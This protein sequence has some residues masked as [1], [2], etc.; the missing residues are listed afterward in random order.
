LALIDGVTP[1]LVEALFRLGWR[2]AAD[3]SHSKPDELV[4]VPGIDA[5]LAPR[6][7]TSA[8]AVEAERR[9]QAEEAT[10]AA[11][12]V[13]PGPGEGADAVSPSSTPEGP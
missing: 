11:A 6:L 1:E 13:A 5:D 3:V 4:E 9:R 7:I 2:S 12:A 10:L 8:R